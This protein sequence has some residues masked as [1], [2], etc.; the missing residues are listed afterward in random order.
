MSKVT[1]ELN[2]EGVRELLQSAEMMSICKE[3]AEGIKDDYG[4]DAE[5]TTYV[6][7]NRVNASVVAPLK[8]SLKDN[9]LL[10]AM[11]GRKGK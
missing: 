11:G 3:L 7:V 2:S 6:G 5:V 10:K 9:S 1:I 4:P 8:K